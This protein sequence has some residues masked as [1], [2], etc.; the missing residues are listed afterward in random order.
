MKIFSRIAAI[1]LVVAAVTMMSGAA[2]APESAGGFKTGDV[3][4][5]CPKCHEGELI[6]HPIQNGDPVNDYSLSCSDSTGC[7]F[8][9]F[10]LGDDI[11][12]ELNR[13]Y[14]RGIDVLHLNFK[15]GVNEIIPDFWNTKI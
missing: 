3:I 4:S 1:V 14:I 11:Y 5:V 7:G 8:N 2:V 6:F 9:M 12:A 15:E 10:V 13:T